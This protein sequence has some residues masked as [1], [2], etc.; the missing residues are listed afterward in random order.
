[1]QRIQRALNRVLSLRGTKNT[2]LY[3]R[4]SFGFVSSV[5]IILLMAI[6]AISPPFEW[7]LE[8]D[9][10]C[11]EA[12]SRFLYMSEKIIYSENR[13]YFQMVKC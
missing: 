13:L 6:A 3:L 10:N 8:T 4:F 12:T 11:R 5:N 7:A 2:F 1:M 9:V